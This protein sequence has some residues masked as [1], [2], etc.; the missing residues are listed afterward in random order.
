MT[1][2]TCAFSCNMD[3]VMFFFPFFLK[4]V[5]NLLRE[6]KESRWTVS[7]VHVCLCIFF[8]WLFFFS[9][10][11]VHTW[12]LDRSTVFFFDMRLSTFD[13]CNHHGWLGIKNQLSGNYPA[14]S[15][16][17][18]NSARPSTARIEWR[19]CVCSHFLKP[20]RHVDLCIVL[21]GTRSWE[22]KSQELWTDSK[23]WTK[24]HLTSTAVEVSKMILTC[25]DAVSINPWQKVLLNT[26]TRG[27]TFGFYSS[28]LLFGFWRLI[29]WFMFLL[30]CMP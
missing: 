25:T 15:Y 4:I 12:S 10:E 23:C 27:C 14:F 2:F 28:H 8:S 6:K 18:W 1:E 9:R 5:Y 11:L 24:C 29:Y 21:E 17:L 19:D 7:S 20:F 16:D 30:F 26:L 3:L 13:G 22:F